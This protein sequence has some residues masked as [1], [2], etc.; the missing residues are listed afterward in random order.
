MRLID[1][2]VTGRTKKIFTAA[3]DLSQ[4]G[5][6][7]TLTEMVLRYNVG[8]TIDLNNVGMALL[9]ETPGR[10][11]VAIDSVQVV[12]LSVE[13]SAQKITL[14]KIGVTGGDSLTINGAVIPLAE[15]R[16]AHTE[17]FPKLFG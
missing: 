8:A 15:L 16:K 4:G 13:A 17:T 9:S 10:V 7:A 12:A 3:H 14:T 2:L 5:L 11:V 6:A 1:L